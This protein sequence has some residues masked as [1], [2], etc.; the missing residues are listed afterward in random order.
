MV[1]SRNSTRNQVHEVVWLKVTFFCWE[2][3]FTF[4]SFEETL[5]TTVGLESSYNGTFTGGT[6]AY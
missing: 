4:F 6:N 2:R 1:P 3:D 5:N